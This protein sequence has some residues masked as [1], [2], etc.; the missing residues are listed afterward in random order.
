MVA[1]QGKRL[2]MN[3]FYQDNSPYLSN[4]VR[5]QLLGTLELP[6]ESSPSMEATLDDAVQ[7]APF[8]GGDGD[9]KIIINAFGSNM[10]IVQRGNVSVRG[11]D[12][13]MCDQDPI[14]PFGE[15]SSRKWKGKEIIPNI[16]LNDIEDSYSDLEDMNFDKVF[17]VAGPIANE[18]QSADPTAVPVLLPVKEEKKDF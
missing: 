10:D 11:E 6:S 9:T 3:D 7:S 1:T 5:P 18:A 4:Y 12:F 8:V 2:D 15:E 13:E 17:D 14:A 16:D